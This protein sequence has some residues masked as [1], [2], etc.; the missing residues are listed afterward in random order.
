MFRGGRTY[1]EVVRGGW[2]CMKVYFRWF[3]V[4]G[5]FY[6]LVGLV[7]RGEWG[8]SSVSVSPIIIA[9]FQIAP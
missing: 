3:E 8:W 9:F 4:G 2:A 5:H 7:F 6:G 1:F